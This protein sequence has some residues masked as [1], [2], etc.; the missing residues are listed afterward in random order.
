[1]TGDD[2]HRTY[3]DDEIADIVRKGIYSLPGPSY[4]P[5]RED[6]PGLT[7]VPLFA[8]VMDAGKVRALFR[9]VPVFDDA[10]GYLVDE[11]AGTRVR[12]DHIEPGITAGAGDRESRR[13]RPTVATYDAEERAARHLP[14]LWVVYDEDRDIYRFDM[15]PRNG[16][17]HRV[18]SGHLFDVQ[19]DRLARE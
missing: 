10:E 7:A 8:R 6:P 19:A 2:D 15:R 13:E 17:G 16:K 11:K 1:M 3:T 5:L 12:L 4:N 14:V 18:H 9:L